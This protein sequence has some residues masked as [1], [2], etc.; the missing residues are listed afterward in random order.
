MHVPAVHLLVLPRTPGRRGRT[1]MMQSACSARQLTNSSRKAEN[2]TVNPSAST[3][4]SP[5]MKI[6]VM[7]RPCQYLHAPPTVE[8]SGRGSMSLS[9]KDP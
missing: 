8:S 5:L 7:P 6:A 3:F 9:I 4:S 2:A 1:C